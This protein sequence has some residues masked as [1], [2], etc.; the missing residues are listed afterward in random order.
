MYFYTVD[1]FV[2]VRVFGGGGGLHVKAFISGYIYSTL[3]A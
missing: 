1:I 2:C 3:L